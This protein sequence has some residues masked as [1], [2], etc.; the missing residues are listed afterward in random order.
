MSASSKPAAPL[1]PQH[2]PEPRIERVRNAL[3]VPVQKG[4]RLPSGVF[5]MNGTFCE[6]SQTLLSQNRFSERPDRPERQGLM[7]ISG[8]HVYGGVARDHFGHFLLES[9][10]RL[11][12]FDH[13]DAPVDGVL[14]S[15][16]RTSDRLTLFN[17]RYQP[18]FDALC[19]SA[20]PLMFAEP[21]VVE[22]LL[23]PSPGFGHQAWITGTT[24]F[25]DAIRMRLENAFP[26]AGVD[27]LYISRTRLEGVEKAVDKERR[28]ER[29]MARS[30]Y[31]IFHPQDHDIETQIKQYRA[32]KRIVAPDGSA[33]HLAAFVARPDAK[34]AV[35]QR[36]HRQKIVQAFIE[37]FCA[38][39]VS[40]VQL[41]NPLAPKDNRDS[42]AGEAPDPL[43]FRLL[44]KQLQSA[45]FL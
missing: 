18:L 27:D 4:G 5:R 11:W 37:Q 19:G 13:L 10:G 22:E 35:L 16:R 25:R 3:V 43:N 8:R 12:V 15:P 44:A 40:D 26:A 24:Q 2:L 1:T 33:L 41:I 32:A 45:D 39:G 28:I 14:F 29:L 42:A 34:I 38:F 21:V 9:L 36:R 17:P 6:H 20:A 30:G 23:L 31:Q 7:R